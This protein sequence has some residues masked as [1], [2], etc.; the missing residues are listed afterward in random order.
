MEH[1]IEEENPHTVVL[2][3]GGNDLPDRDLSMKDIVKVAEHLIKGGLKCRNTFGVSDVLISSILPR[4]HSDFQG[5]R[6]RLNIVLREMCEKNGFMFIENE[7]IILR[8][9]GHHDGVH[10]NREG[11]NLLHRNLLFALNNTR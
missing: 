4:S 9:H 5:N 1:H 2:V 6:H 3:A 8:P 7:N 10:L 11:S